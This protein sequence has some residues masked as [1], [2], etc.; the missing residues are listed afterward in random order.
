VGSC[1]SC[2]KTF[3]NQFYH[4]RLNRHD[5]LVL[6][7]ELN[8]E[9]EGYRAIEP[10][11]EEEPDGEGT[12]SNTREAQLQRLLIEHHFPAGNCR[13]R[14]TTSTGLSTEP[15]WLHEQSKVAVYLDGMSRHLH[16]DPRTAQRDQLIRQALELDGYKVIVVQSRDLDD[17]EAVRQHLRSIAQA[18]GREDMIG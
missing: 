3:R 12:P 5:A 6:M 10:V 9:P 15:D 18:L 8:H 16:G 17:P 7:D 11:F 13:E 2:L 1:Y 4:A 14:V